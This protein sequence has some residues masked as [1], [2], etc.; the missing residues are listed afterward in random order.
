MGSLSIWTLSRGRD[1]KVDSDGRSWDG[2][3]A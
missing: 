1:G 3:D 2:D